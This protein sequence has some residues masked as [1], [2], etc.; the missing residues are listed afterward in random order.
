MSD[1]VSENYKM[2][3]EEPVLQSS[4]ALN[5]P[6][7]Y[8]IPV[9]EAPSNSRKI[10]L[11]SFNDLMGI[12]LTFFVLLYSMSQPSATKKNEPSPATQPILEQAQARG[13]LHY[14]GDKDVIS[15]NRIDY[16]ASLDLSYLQSVLENLRDKNS[17][18][19]SLVI[20]SD[21]PN[22]R[23]IL[24]LPQELLFPSGKVRIKPEGRAAILLLGEAL[25]G[26]KNGITVV[27]HSDPNQP[28]SGMNNWELSLERATAVAAFIKEAGYKRSIPVQGF[29]AG[30]YAQLPQDISQSAR[31]RLARR[32]DIVIY[33]HDG[34]LQRRFGIAG[35]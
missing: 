34:S 14:A 18:L 9:I 31:D 29:A 20:Q 8:P 19:K 15:L 13:T 5:A 30:L 32:V 24:S 26:I 28:Q 3:V 2:N 33:D 7:S 22:Q 35:N 21:L 4:T 11:L 27:G 23:L 6:V 16:N 25:R 17:N 10:W 12:L 1:H